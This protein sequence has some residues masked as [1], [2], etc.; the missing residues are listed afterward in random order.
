MLIPRCLF[1]H[2]LSRV[3]TLNKRTYKVCIDC[4]RQFDYDLKNM[5]IVRDQREVKKKNQARLYIL[6]TVKGENK[7]QIKKL[8]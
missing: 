4:G 7:W 2:R 6:K 1:S 5:V 3:W 8:K